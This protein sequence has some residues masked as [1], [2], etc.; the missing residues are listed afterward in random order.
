MHW[1][2]KVIKYGD[3]NWLKCV[4]LIKYV[5]LRYQSTFILAHISLEQRNDS[6]PLSSIFNQFIFLCW[7]FFKYYTI[8]YILH[9]IFFYRQSEELFI[10]IYFKLKTSRLFHIK[11]HCNGTHLTHFHIILLSNFKHI[12]AVIFLDLPIFHFKVKTLDYSNL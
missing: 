6:L 9:F 11:V 8:T 4:V 3:W 10:L 12:N 1:R 5:I 2:V 7:F